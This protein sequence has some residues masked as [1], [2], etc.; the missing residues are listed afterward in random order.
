MAE[1]INYD[2]NTQ[3]QKFR[4][5]AKHLRYQ[6][7]F[8]L[9]L[10]ASLLLMAVTVF[11]L[12]AD[13]A[14]N[15]VSANEIYKNSKMVQKKIADIKNKIP[16][17]PELIISKNVQSNYKKF[18]DEF[19]EKLGQWDE[20]IKEI[21]DKIKQTSVTFNL[22][23]LKNTL[24][25]KDISIRPKV[26]TK[27]EMFKLVSTSE[28]S[29]NTF[30]ITKNSEEFEKLMFLGNYNEKLLFIYQ[31]LLKISK[32]AD[33]FIDNF[34]NSFNL[35]L[36]KWE[37]DTAQYRKELSDLSSGLKYLEEE[38]KKALVGLSNHFQQK[39][40]I[41][42]LFLIQTNIT[43]FGPMFIIFFLVSIL[44]NLYRYNTR[45]SAYYDARA[46]AMILSELNTNSDKMEKYVTMLSPDSHDLGA[47]PKIP[48][49]QIM[50]IAK[51]TITAVTPTKK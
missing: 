21:D 37:K 1:E 17:K 2:K 49:Q 10:I 33:K 43:R 35:E 40:D 48:T 28:S 7:W 14:R 22:L 45:L 36:S 8:A 18:T 24:N 41:S 44:I 9:F 12:A 34:Y 47:P 50:D 13:I 5:R 20:I 26:N 31:D 6:A 16:K 29:L 11:Y 15:D 30:I 32:N 3:I 23:D 39:Q 38:E 27:K 25:I 51:S 42:V 4:R 46:D 19:S